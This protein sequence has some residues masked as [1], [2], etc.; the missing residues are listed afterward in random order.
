[1]RADRTYSSAANRAHLRRRGIKATTPIKTDQAAHRKKKG[2][3]GG[4][5][6]AFDTEDYT[7]RHAVDCGIG[8]LNEHR[9]VA[10]RFDK[11]AVRYQA[12]VYIAAINQWLR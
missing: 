4:R 2:T 5:P 12:T 1:M 6:P 11:L 7:M 8:Q 3:A 9:A 10:T